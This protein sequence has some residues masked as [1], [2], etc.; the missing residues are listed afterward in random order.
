MSRSLAT[1]IFLVFMAGSA[2]S[3]FA[4][5]PALT[6][7]MEAHKIILNGEKREIAVPAENV[8]PE[9]TIEYTLRY[10]NSGDSSAKGVDLV[11]PIP[12]GTIYLKKTA[13]EIEG[14]S[15]LFSIDGGKTYQHEPVMYEVVTKDGAVE[16]K[17]ATPDMYTHIKWSMGG[18]F[19]VGQEVVVSYR[20]QVK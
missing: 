11:G 2:A 3:A 18:A 1:A 12:E 6:G 7:E 13:S 5:G 8:Y 4:G 14:S 16:K 10:R 19:D 15:P 9:D 17:K 20:V